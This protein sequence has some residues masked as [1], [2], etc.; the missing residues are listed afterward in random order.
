M[1]LPDF[2]RCQKLK[3]GDERSLEQKNAQREAYE[4]DQARGLDRQ[5]N[6]ARAQD[7]PQRDCERN[8]R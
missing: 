7:R 4:C 6:V 8:D 5:A 2:S 3:T 1:V